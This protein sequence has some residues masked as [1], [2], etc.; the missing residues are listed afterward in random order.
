MKILFL[1]DLHIGARNCNPNFLKM[2]QDYFNNELFPYIKKHNITTVIQLGDILDKRRNVDF[3]ISNFLINTF[4]NFFEENK[5]HFYSTIGNHDIYYRQSIKIDGPSQL[6]KNDSFIHIIKTCKEIIFDNINVCFIPW[7]CDENK[8]DV[9]TFIQQHKNKNC[10][11]CGHFELAGFPIQKGYI[12]DKGSIDLKELSNFMY[13]LS[14]HYH[15]PSQKNNIIYIGTPYELTWSDYGDDKKFLVFDTETKSFESVYTKKK[16]YH[17]IIY[18]DEIFKTLNYE[19]YK[20]TY[21]KVLLT[22]DYNEGK[23]NLFLTMLDE[24]S[25]PYSIQTIDVREQQQHLVEEISMNDVDNPIE[26]MMNTI[27]SIVTDKS[28]CQTVKNLTHEIY[29]TAMDNLQ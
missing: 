6:V 12:S 26:I 16:L 21:I 3:T 19:Q 14:G 4:Y 10:I 24:K 25:Q 29:Q 8:K 11:L 9:L 28:L 15:S 13:V 22:G 1:G 18:N 27:D 23:L 2:M 5:V 17:K 20:N 7:I